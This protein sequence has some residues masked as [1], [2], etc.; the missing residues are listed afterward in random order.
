MSYKIRKRD[1]RD[2]EGEDKENEE[3][4]GEKD[5]KKGRA[6]IVN[7]GTLIVAHFKYIFCIFETKSTFYNEF[8][9]LIQCYILN[10]FNDT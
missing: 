3:G 6:S 8:K 10:I 2:K 1:V 9:N 5:G 7:W 4:K